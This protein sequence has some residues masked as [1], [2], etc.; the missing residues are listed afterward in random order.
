MGNLKL[1]YSAS[2]YCQ[3]APWKCHRLSRLELVHFATQH[4]PGEPSM[5]RVM[6]IAPC[7]IC[8]R[9]QRNA[10]IQFLVP[11]TQTARKPTA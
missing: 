6:D 5:Q 8:E 10:A 2:M 4:H 1:W 11:H 3:Q 9:A 7:Y